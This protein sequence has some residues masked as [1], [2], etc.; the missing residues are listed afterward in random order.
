[1]YIARLSFQPYTTLSVA[2]PQLQTGVEV[3]CMKYK[4]LFGFF[5]R[6]FSVGNKIKH[7]TKAAQYVIAVTEA[8]VVLSQCLVWNFPFSFSVR[9][10]LTAVAGIIGGFF[11]VASW[12]RFGS[13]LLAMFIIGLVL[14][15]LFSSTVFFTPL[16]MCWNTLLQI[17]GYWVK[18]SC[19]I[20]GTL[21]GS[22]INATIWFIWVWCLTFPFPYWGNRDV[23]EAFQVCCN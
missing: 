9:L 19:C 23:T 22:K 15:F 10:I 2:H 1:M 7:I 21:Q 13:V 16:G 11:L 14:G 4:Y 3:K 18:H 20:T 5:F 6:K 8:F 12:W 17:G